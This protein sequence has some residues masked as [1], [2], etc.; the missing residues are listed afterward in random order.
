MAWKQQFEEHLG[1]TEGR[2]SAFSECIPERQC[3]LRCLYGN[4]GAGWSH[5]PPLPLRINTEPPEVNCRTDTGCLTCL[6]QTPPPC[7]LEE[8]L[9]SVFFLS[10][11]KLASVTASQTL[12][13]KDQH[14]PLPT[15]H[16]LTRVF[17]RASVLVELVSGIISQTDHSTPS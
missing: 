7:T 16:L 11:H 14:K 2:L 17:C 10:L 1:H 3:S 13:P 8:L 6:H 5:F 15:P 9:F 12:P 4:K